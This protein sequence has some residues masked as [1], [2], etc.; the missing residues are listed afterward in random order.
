M[1]FLKKKIPPPLVALLFGL[2]M[3]FSSDSFDEIEIP[4]KGYF[5]IIFLVLGVLITFLSAR[6]FR[7]K[8]TTVNPLT[9]D[10]ATSLV[11]DGMFKISRNPMYLGL[12]SVLIA[13]SFY[14]GLIVGII[15]VPLFML[16]ITI[17]QIIPEEEAMLKLF[18][19]EYKIYSSKVR[20]WI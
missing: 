18:G 20:R 19:D 17:F 11:T 15:F 3:Y 14:K 16:Y 8:E 2:I 12:T 9:P 1:K 7:I 4:L 10:K 5:S 13:L 6:T